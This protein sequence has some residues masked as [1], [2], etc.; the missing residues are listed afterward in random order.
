MKMEFDENRLK[1][2]L[3]KGKYVWYRV[4]VVTRVKETRATIEEDDDN[5]RYVRDGVYKLWEDEAAF[6]KNFLGLNEGEYKGFIEVKEAEIVACQDID[7]DC[8]K[9]GVFAIKVAD[10]PKNKT[11]K[12]A[13]A[14]QHGFYC[15]KV[16]GEIEVPWECIFGLWEDE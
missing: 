8:M 11:E 13:I 12:K 16:E 1:E 14:K 4:A 15:A 3:K 6:I 2:L 7:W 5:W 9:R 10:V